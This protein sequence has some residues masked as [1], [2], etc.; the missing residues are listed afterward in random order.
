MA[1]LNKMNSK[2][3]VDGSHIFKAES[4]S[5]EL[6]ELLD[7][8]FRLSKEKKI[9]YVE[10]NKSIRARSFKNADIVY[11]QVKAILLYSFNCIVIPEK[12]RLL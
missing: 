6:L 10:H 4:P 11:K 2:V 9:V 12:R 3:V 8:F 7:L 5:N 1:I